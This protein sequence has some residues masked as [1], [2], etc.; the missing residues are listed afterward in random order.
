MIPAP[1]TSRHMKMLNQADYTCITKQKVVSPP[2]EQYTRK[3][4][5]WAFASGKPR[6]Y[7]VYRCAWGFIPVGRDQNLYCKEGKWI[8]GHPQCKYAGEENLKL[9]MCF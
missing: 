6:L 1:K 2:N 5:E 4:V 7:T 9:E 3:T 8:G